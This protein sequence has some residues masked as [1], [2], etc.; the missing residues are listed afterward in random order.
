MNV[1]ERI[2][3]IRVLDRKKEY[4]M[5]FKKLGVSGETKAYSGNFKTDEFSIKKE[6]EVE[7][8]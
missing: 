6:R 2:I 5:Y 7:R 1:K 3:S 8:C 4:P